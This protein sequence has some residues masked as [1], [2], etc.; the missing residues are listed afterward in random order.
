MTVFLFALVG[1]IDQFEFKTV[2]DPI[3]FAQNPWLV[4]S[5]PPWV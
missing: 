5:R 2:P 3:W 4:D 1:R